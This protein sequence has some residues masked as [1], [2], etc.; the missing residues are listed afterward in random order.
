MDT[1][2]KDMVVILTNRLLSTKDK[3]RI[4]VLSKQLRFAM[5][6]KAKVNR[7]VDVITGS[8]FDSIFNSL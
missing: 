5:L 4:K 8:L 2:K 1:N 7:P 6:H 3:Q